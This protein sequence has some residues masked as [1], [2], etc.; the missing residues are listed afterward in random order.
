MSIDLDGTEDY[1]LVACDGV[2]D[3]LSGDEIVECVHKHLSSPGGS[4][5]SVAK[6]LIQEARSEG[7][8]DNMTVIVSFFSSFKE[9]LMTG[10]SSGDMPPIETKDS[11]LD[12]SSVDKTEASPVDTPPTGTATGEST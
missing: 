8:A 12:P 3:V 9:D 5:Q 7:S 11:T 2:W 4:R 6:A 1:L 10:A